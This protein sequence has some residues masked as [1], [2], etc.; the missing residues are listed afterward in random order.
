LKPKLWTNRKIRLQKR[1]RR[2]ALAASQRSY[3]IEIAIAIDTGANLAQTLDTAL[4]I[5]NIQILCKSNNKAPQAST[6]LH[7]FYRFYKKDTRM[8]TLDFTSVIMRFRSFI[9]LVPLLPLIFA[10]TSP[11][12]SERGSH[13]R[14]VYGESCWPSKDEF[15][16]LASN[17]TQPLIYPVPP[18]SACYPVGNPSGNCTDVQTNWFDANWREDIPGAYE[19]INFEAYTNKN[20]SIS[21]CYLN[22][23]LGFPCDQGSVPPIGVDARTVEDIQAAVEFAA[24]HNL[25]LVVKNTG[26]VLSLCQYHTAALTKHPRRHDYLGRSAG[27]DAFMI[28][29]HNLKN[30]T[31][32]ASFIPEGGSQSD[33]V[34]GRHF[35]ACAH[36]KNSR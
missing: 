4:P 13:C 30:I 31:Y 20:G 14:C 27:R 8:V 5:I 19:N 34:S 29:T 12:S 24:R 35:F 15:S 17:L 7:R 32:D 3:L 26:Y 33:T 22:T 21:A 9:D 1:S 6:F 11:P 10:Q 36:Q 25:R 18:A 28:W 16:S 23:T 2:S